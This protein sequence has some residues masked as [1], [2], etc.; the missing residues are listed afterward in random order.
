[1]SHHVGEDIRSLRKSRGMTL[2]ELAGDVGRSVGWL[3]QVERGQTTPSV[4]DLGQI[5]DRLGVNIS[6]F[7]RSAS[8]APEERGLVLRAADRTPIGSQESGLVE[9]LLSPT[10]SGSFEMIKST[11][12][13]RSSSGGRR[14]ARPKEDG[15]VLIS[16]R[17]TLIIGDR[18]IRLEPGDSF[19]FR[20]TDYAW[21]NDGDEPAIAIWIVSPPIY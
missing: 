13:P 7:F 10:L 11:F 3:S 12:A 15:G 6:F 1:M 18:E 4:R 17:L 9:E 21:R 14:K 5:S 16:G 19:Q 2:L 8:R 20:E